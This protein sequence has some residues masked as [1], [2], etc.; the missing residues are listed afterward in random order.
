[1]REEPVRKI[2]LVDNTNPANAR[3]IW[4]LDV[5]GK[6]D[7]EVTFL[8]FDI[9]RRIPVQTHFIQDTKAF[10]ELPCQPWP[11]NTMRNCD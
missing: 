2:Q 3:C 7:K 10:Q 11:G 6:A 4:E 9:L 1:M 5:S 8:G